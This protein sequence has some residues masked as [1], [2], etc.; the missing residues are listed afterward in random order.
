MTPCPYCEAPH[1]R[2]GVYCSATCRT[3]AHRASNAAL[4]KRAK[5]CPLCN[6]PPPPVGIRLACRCGAEKEFRA[7]HRFSQLDVGPKAQAWIREH[8]GC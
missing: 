6:D 7:L 2:K 1:E 3:S 5:Y 8:E 4:A